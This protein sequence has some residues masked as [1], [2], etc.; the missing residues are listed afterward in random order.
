[1]GEFNMV[2]ASAA[3]GAQRLRGSE[4]ALL[5]GVMFVSIV[6]GA[7]ATPLLRTRVDERPASGEPMGLTND[8]A[9]DVLVIGYGRVGAIAARL[10]ARAG[11]RSLVIEPDAGACDRAVR[12]G[13]EVLRL[14]GTDP[15][16]LD[17]TVGPET[18]LVV[19]TIPDTHANATIAQRLRARGVP[20][21]ARAVRN[22]DAPL[23]REAGAL[24]SIS[25][26]TEGAYDLARAGLRS[27]N[28]TPD[29]I[30]EYVATERAKSL[31]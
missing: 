24:E 5:A 19:T 7:A 20:V 16:A 18:Q 31:G 12:D 11:R 28:F 1:M 21:V 2:L 3:L 13:F 29:E 14:D 22:D 27:M 4:F 9:A 25:P 15:T 30:E 10:F 23:L 17:R 6:A 8:V 26:E